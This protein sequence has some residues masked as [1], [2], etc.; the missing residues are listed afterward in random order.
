MT[1]RPRNDYPA[2]IAD[3][4]EQTATRIRSVTVERASVAITWTAL[5][6]VLATIAVLAVRDSSF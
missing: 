2:K 5:G 4:L 1:D 6:L 3:F